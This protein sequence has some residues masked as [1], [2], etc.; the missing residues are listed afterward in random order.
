MPRYPRA[1]AFVGPLDHPIS[2]DKSLLDDYARSSII[3]G[4]YSYGYPYASPYTGPYASPYGYVGP[5][6]GAYG[7]YAGPYGYLGAYAGPYTSPYFY[8]APFYPY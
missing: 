6:A 8:S 5:Y 1:R 7:S 3:N 4:G 2:H